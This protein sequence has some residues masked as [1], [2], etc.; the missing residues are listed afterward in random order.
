MNEGP[1][2]LDAFTYD[3]T[4]P[5]FLRWKIDRWGGEH[6]QSKKVSAGDVAGIRTGAR[7]E[8]R[9]QGVLYI[10]SRVIWYLH[11]GLIPEGWVVDHQD[12]NRTNGRI[13]NLRA[14]TEIINRQNSCARSDNTSG[15][16]GVNRTV[17]SKGYASW[18]AHW[19]E[20][21]G[22]KAKQK[23]FGI[24]KYGEEGAKQ[25]AVTYRAAKI[26][27]LNQRGGSYTERHGK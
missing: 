22:G 20:P 3:E 15:T 5:T 11:F 7:P 10:A 23:H 1:H 21:D 8:V 18:R 19:K 12:G 6:G 17:D 4:S 25:L 2:L 9:Y 26:L 13:G 27:D 16:C 14:V 24:P